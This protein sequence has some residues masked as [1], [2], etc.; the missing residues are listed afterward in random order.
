MHQDGCSSVL[1]RCH[2]LSTSG[3]RAAIKGSADSPCSSSRHAGLGVGREESDRGVEGSR[4]RK[5]GWKGRGIENYG[6]VRSQSEKAEEE[7]TQAE[8]S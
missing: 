4:E 8:D 2:L 6:A 7:K 1:G 3:C 5:L